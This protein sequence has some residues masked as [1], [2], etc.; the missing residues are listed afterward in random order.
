MPSPSNPS[1]SRPPSRS[2]HPAE[3]S[4]TR[5][6]SRVAARA[7]PSPSSSSPFERVVR[8][9]RLVHTTRHRPLLRV[10]VPLTRDAHAPRA[11]PRAI[12]GASQIRSGARYALDR[13]R[14]SSPAIPPPRR[15]RVRVT[16]VLRHRGV[17]D[18]RT[19]HDDRRTHAIRTRARKRWIASRSRTPWRRAGRVREY[20]VETRAIGDG[21]GRWGW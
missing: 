17:D 19:T 1:P 10:R 5:D 2:N 16:D 21:R 7:S 3:G 14:A 11:I 20:R 15:R 6:L 9:R 18:R 4:A 8:A 13:D 12:L